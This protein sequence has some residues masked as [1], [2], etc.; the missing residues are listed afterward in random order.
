[1]PLHQ[2]LGSQLTAKR[3]RENLWGKH[4][5][6]VNILKKAR[7]SHLLFTASEWLIPDQ[8]RFA[9]WFGKRHY[10]PMCFTDESSWSML[11]SFASWRARGISECFNRHEIIWD[12][13]HTHHISVQ[14]NS[15]FC[16]KVFTLL[17]TFMK[18]SSEGTCFGR[19]IRR[20]MFL[21]VGS[22]DLSLYIIY[23]MSFFY[24][25]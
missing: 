21:S 4:L 23:P 5:S 2:N 14:L 6:C 1:M 24:I 13:R 12:G 8:R 18:T 19:R 7:R 17:I 3:I 10:K 11:R 20:R 16:T 25:T 22:R 9:A 15:W